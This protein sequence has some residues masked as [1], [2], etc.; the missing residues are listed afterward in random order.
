[1]LPGLTPPM[2]AANKAPVR[3][4]PSRATGGVAPELIRHTTI[5]SGGTVQRAAAAMVKVVL[6]PCRDGG[7]EDGLQVVNSGCRVKPLG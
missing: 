1:M 2:V 4:H 3:A 6:P 7:S 5:A